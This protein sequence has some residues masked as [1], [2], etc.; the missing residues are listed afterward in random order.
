MEM[1]LTPICYYVYKVA[2]EETGTAFPADK[3]VVPENSQ[4]SEIPTPSP[5]AREP[6]F[7]KSSMQEPGE[8]VEE[9]RSG[10]KV[11]GFPSGRDSG[12]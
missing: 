8:N 4:Y 3:D 1:T 2:D 9:A 12:E 11:N 7:S 10:V 6:S 5:S